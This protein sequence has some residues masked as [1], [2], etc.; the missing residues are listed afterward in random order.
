M[1]YWL[2]ICV[3]I[4]GFSLVGCHSFDTSSS[5]RSTSPTASSDPKSVNRYQPASRQ[6]K[7]QPDLNF[8]DY[9]SYVHQHLQRYRVPVK[10]FD[11]EAQLTWNLPFERRPAPFCT[12]SEIRG[13]LWVHGL[14]DSP[15]VFRELIESLPESQCLWVRTIL[16]QGHGTR[17]GD[18]IEA[19]AKDWQRSV[20]IRAQELVEVT[21]HPIY[22]GGFSTGGALVTSWALDHPRDVSGLITVAPAWALNGSV[23]RYLWL[24]PV[25]AWFMDFVK[26]EE[27]LN[28]VKYGTLAMNAAAQIGEVLDQVQSRLSTQMNWPFPVV[29]LTAESDSVINVDVLANYFKR[30]ARV[31]GSR[32]IMFHDRRATLPDWWDETT[33]TDWPGYFPDLHILNISHMSLNFSRDNQLYGEKGP[34]SRCIEPHGMSSAQCIQLPESQLWFSAWRPGESGPPTSRL[35][36]TPYFKQW[37]GVI[38]DFVQETRFKRHDSTTLDAHSSTITMKRLPGIPRKVK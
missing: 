8:D 5:D 38:R 30:S 15:Y 27:E 20:S 23:E 37:V 4:S 11:R 26:T 9:L 14:N 31:N 19:S 6:L 2:L 1:P 36:W 17:P 28:P 24:A 32:W 12:Q 33:M 25:A 21:G 10:G 34:L 13:M 3:V 7:P 18:M 35:T 16:L 22:L 29:M